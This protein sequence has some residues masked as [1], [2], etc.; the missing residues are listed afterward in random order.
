MSQTSVESG[1]SSDNGAS[2]SPNNF[3]IE[4]D[5]RKF[6]RNFEVTDLLTKSVNGVIYNGIHLRS[7]K[8]VVIK[9]IPRN[10]VQEYFE[11][12]GRL[13]PSEIYFH[14]HAFAIS[15]SV[16]KPIAWFEKRSSFVLVMENS[17]TRSTCGNFQTLS[18]LFP[19]TLRLQ[20]FRKFSNVPKNCTR[21][22]LLIGIS[23][24]KIF[25]SIPNRLRS[26]LS[27]LAVPK[28][29]K[30]IRPSKTPRAL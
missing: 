22:V 21:A 9:Q 25:S 28:R 3:L 7:G 5:Q 14:F 29:S 10:V 20:S 18:A 1:Y 4:K 2:R 24:T 8:E 13:V 16:V 26:K 11:I 12:D 15:K 27:I 30:K 6:D 17:K 23:R 19:K